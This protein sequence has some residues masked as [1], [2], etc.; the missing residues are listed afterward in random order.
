V[1]SGKPYLRTYGLLAILCLSASGCDQT[2]EPIE[3]TVHQRVCDPTHSWTKRTFEE[4]CGAPTSHVAGTLQVHIDRTSRVAT[5]N[6]VT[7]VSIGD[8]VRI[9]D[10]VIHDSKN[11]RC[12]E[13]PDGGIN[14]VYQ[15][16]NGQFRFTTLYDTGLAPDYWTGDVTPGRTIS[17]APERTDTSSAGGRISTVAVLTMAYPLPD[18]GAKADLLGTFSSTHDCLAARNAYL[19]KYPARFAQ[20]GVDF[21]CILDVLN[22]TELETFDATAKP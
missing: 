22:P 6:D 20:R 16:V 10:C 9:N 5:F 4:A 21:A 14:R 12:E 15:M 11:W 8:E 1:K 19:A 7:I 2:S 18:G 17:L 13:P 3:F